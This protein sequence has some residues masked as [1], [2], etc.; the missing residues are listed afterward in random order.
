MVVDH[1]EKSTLMSRLIEC[2]GASKLTERHVRFS[3]MKL[4]LVKKRPDGS[5]TPSCKAMW[6]AAL[7][8]ELGEPTAFCLH[9]VRG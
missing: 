9:S 4:R 1:D 6:H 7:R 5:K 2:R 8:T 3:A